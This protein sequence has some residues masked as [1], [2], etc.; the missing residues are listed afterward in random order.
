MTPANDADLVLHGGKIWTGFGNRLAQAIAVTGNK[1][2][3]TGDNAEI[4][5]LVGP[6]TRVIDLAGRFAM[7]G[8]NDAHLHLISTGLT[9]RQVDA[10]PEAAPTREALIAALQTRAADTP[11]GGWVIARGFDQTRYPD[12][13]M[14][15]AQ[16][17]DAALPNHLVSVTRACGHVTVANTAA[18]TAAGI[19]ADTP[20][21]DGGVIGREAGQL[22]GML[23]DNAQQMLYNIR[24][25]PSLDDIIGAI[26]DGGRHLIEFGITSCMDAATGQIDGMTEIEAYLQAEK[27]GRLPVRV[28]ATLLGDP[29]SSIVEPCHEAGL[30]AGAGSDMFR[31]GGVKVFTDGSA[32]GRTAWMSEPYIDQP[33]NYGVKILP[34]EQLFELVQ[35]YHGMGYPLV[36]HGIGDAAIDQLIRAYEDIRESDPE[37]V[38]RDRIEH[39]GFATDEMNQRMVAAGILPAPQQVFLHDFGDGYVT[40]L[41]PERALPSYPIGTWDRLGLKPST[42][43]DSPVCSPNPFPNLHAMLTRQTHK[44]TVMDASEILTAEQALRAYT[45]YGAY[46]QSA[47]TVKGRLEPGML[48]DIAIFS[49]DLLTAAPDT[50]LNETRCEMTILDGRVVHDLFDKT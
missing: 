9:R 28:W 35:R 47:E 17:L 13:L 40:V 44:G 43:S 31:I 26:E 29:G 1:V 3:A 18:L 37:N 23:A 12:G 39:C 49:Q 22:T 48:A 19:T 27:N 25:T 10:G 7:P 15:T 32:G 4:M 8:L 21:P 33:E 30:V 46:S 5:A 38:Y 11:N 24:P 20:D 36:C 50:I 2:Q 42:G 16:E 41:G 14:P 45:E 6:E 34:D